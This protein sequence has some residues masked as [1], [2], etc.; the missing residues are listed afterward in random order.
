MGDVNGI[1]A[2]FKLT[3]VSRSALQNELAGSV[4]LH[5]LEQ[6]IDEVV[7]VSADGLWTTAP[8]YP[9]VPSALAASRQ[10][11]VRGVTHGSE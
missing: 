6:R 7:T 3:A 11:S 2:T 1:P 5:V 10:N 4:I 9:A 8:G